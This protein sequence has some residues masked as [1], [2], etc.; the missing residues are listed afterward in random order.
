MK[1][2][3]LTII[4]LSFV[5]FFLFGY[6][7]I[8]QAFTNPTGTPPSG[9]DGVISI[10][11]GGTGATTTAQALANLGAAASG[12]N[13]DITSL[14]PLTGNPLQIGNAGFTIGSSLFGIDQGGNIELGGNNSTA[15]PVS[16]GIPYIDFH[17]GTGTAQDYNVRIINNANNS[18]GI[19]ANGSLTLNVG[20]TS[21]DSMIIG[22]GLGTLKV[23]T[24][25]FSD[26]TSQTTAATGIPSGLDILSASQTAPSGYTYTGNYV[27]SGGIGSWTTQSAPPVLSTYP[28][29]DVWGASVNN[30][31]YYVIYN[32][33]QYTIS[34]TTYHAYNYSIQSYNPTSNSWTTIL[35]TA[36]HPSGF[37][38][39]P[40]V[41]YGNNL[42]AFGPFG[43]ETYSTISNSWTTITCPPGGSDTTYF[44]AFSLVA[45]N[46]IVYLIGGYY[47]TGSGWSYYNYN[48]AYNISANSWSTL[49]SMP[50]ARGWTSAAIINNT[51]YVV[52]GNNNNILTTNEAY[53]ITSNSWSEE[54]PMPTAR[55]DLSAFAVNNILY[56]IG[57][58]TSSSG[59]ITYANEAY[60]PGTNSWAEMLPIGNAYYPHNW[61]N[62]SVGT[63]L[64]G[65]IY[66]TNNSNSTT[67]LYEYITPVP[68]YVMSKN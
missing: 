7:F 62:Q 9:G 3:R 6:V 1:I 27:V 40:M 65:N 64:G 46:G 44:N 30:I 52:G 20:S 29:W 16:G 24:I 10:S 41:G 67:S 15:N 21:T 48:Y 47:G 23:G 68:Y 50:T 22:G 66:F 18:L 28:I 42:Y 12:A 43:C 35:N 51:I 19:Y 31:F 59:A 55:E 39:E 8:T 32:L 37:V 26:G 56:A 33:Y 11:E 25:T 60:N 63:V 54:T 45:S 58:T 5:I 38:S 17:Y 61:D 49:A 2:Y 13:S 57:G 34:G 14:T 4:F 36:T 53:N